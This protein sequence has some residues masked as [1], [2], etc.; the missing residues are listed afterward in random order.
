MKECVLLPI[1]GLILRYKLPEAPKLQKTQISHEPKKHDSC[2][3]K[4][5]NLPSSMSSIFIYDFS[6]N[7]YGK[8]C[9]GHEEMNQFSEAEKA[10][11]IALEHTPNDIW[12]IH[13]IAH[14]KEETLR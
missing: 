1:S 6:R 3:C 11:A 14:I 4:L 2:A 8:L 9:F 12:A 10:G 5:E 13:S 7:V